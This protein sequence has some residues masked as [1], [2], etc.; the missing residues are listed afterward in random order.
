[1]P[2]K[3][4]AGLVAALIV[5]SG[6][7]SYAAFGGDDPLQSSPPPAAPVPHHTYVDPH[8]QTWNIP[9]LDI[10][11]HTTAPRLKFKFAY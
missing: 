7:M 6:A 11:G 2:V 4:L 10:Q 8:G 3:M 9:T 5:G 1:M